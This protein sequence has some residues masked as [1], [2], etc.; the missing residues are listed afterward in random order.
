MI[1]TASQKVLA[2][3]AI[4]DGK[5]NAARV[6]GVPQWASSDPNVANVVPAA[7]GLSA[8]VVAGQTGTAQIT[9]TADADLGAGVE[10]IT[11]IGEIEVISGRA[12]VIRLAFAAPTEQ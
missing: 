3:L 5:G 7:D 9:V 4:E 12:S 6:D 8:E 2:T 1:I 10:T 11:G